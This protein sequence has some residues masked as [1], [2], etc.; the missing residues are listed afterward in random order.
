M[1]PGARLLLLEELIP[2]TSELVPGKWIDLLMLAITG[3]RERTEKEYRELLSA[4]HFAL[5]EV[6]VTTA[7]PLNI[8]I[9]KVREMA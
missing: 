8:L 5:E 2:E 6:L 9:A 7:G 3:G 4:A 1:K